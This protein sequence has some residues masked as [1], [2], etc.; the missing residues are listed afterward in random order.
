MIL[1]APREKIK[2]NI[3]SKQK[4]NKK[5]KVLF[6]NLVACSER[7]NGRQKGVEQLLKSH[8][9]TQEHD[10]YFLLGLAAL[11]FKKLFGLVDLLAG[12]AIDKKPVCAVFHEN[13]HFSGQTFS[14]HGDNSHL[15]SFWNDRISSVR[16]TPGCTVTLYEHFGFGGR[17]V[18]RSGGSWSSLLHIQSG[19]NWN[20]KVSSIRCSC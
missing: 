10:D 4:V 9:N 18:S 11:K 15:D 20:D 5:T 3:K 17:S 7:F 1:D 6:K 19:F 13:F 16:V 14:L 2:G 8:L 12:K